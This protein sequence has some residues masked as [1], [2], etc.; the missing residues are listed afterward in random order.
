MIKVKHI[1]DQMFVSIDGVVFSTGRDS[2][3]PWMRGGI[4]IRD[5]VSMDDSDFVPFQGTIDQE[6][7]EECNI[8]EQMVSEDRF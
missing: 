8:E 6:F 4:C 2:S 5:E 7:C 3:C 1:D